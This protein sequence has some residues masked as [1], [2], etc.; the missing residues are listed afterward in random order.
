MA[1]N[2]APC[3]ITLDEI[4]KQTQEDDQLQAVI[5]CVRSGNWQPLLCNDSDGKLFWNIRSELSVMDDNLVLRSSRIV[6]P[7]SLRSQ[8]VKLAHIGHQ[9]IVKTKSLIRE[10]VW[11]PNIDSMVENEVQSC[12]ACQAGKK[13]AP[14]KMTGLPSFMETRKFSEKFV[15]FLKF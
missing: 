8:S 15:E 13:R 5:K 1:Q 7:K 14:L 11:F 2:S 9:G 6:V 12:I 3:A 10:K 4:R